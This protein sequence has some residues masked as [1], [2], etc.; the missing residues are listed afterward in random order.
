MKICDPTC[1]SGGMLIESRKSVE[2]TGGNQTNKVI[3]SCNALQVSPGENATMKFSSCKAGMFVISQICDQ[4][5]S[6][7]EACTNPMINSYIKKYNLTENRSNTST[8]LDVE[9]MYKSNSHDL[10]S[11]PETD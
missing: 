8:N 1:G 5:R 9:A 2:R 10:G 4:H 11:G 3:D 6:S 7:L